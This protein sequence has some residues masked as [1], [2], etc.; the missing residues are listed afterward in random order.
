MIS[1]AYLKQ[2]HSINQIAIYQSF[3]I[4]ITF[5]M[6]IYSR[7]FF[8]KLS[9][10]EYPLLRAELFMF[11]L[12]SL[13]LIPLWWHFVDQTML[14][15]LGVLQTS[16]EEATEEGRSLSHLQGYILIFAMR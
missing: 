5:N 1:S 8:F 9:N 14:W 4:V 2:L 10:N 6:S 13:A 16:S 7:L 11:V 12:C 3:V 15:S